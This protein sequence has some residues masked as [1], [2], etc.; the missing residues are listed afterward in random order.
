MP[1]Y[2]TERGALEE[3]LHSLRRQLYEN[4]ELCI[5]DDGST[6]IDSKSI[7]DRVMLKDSRVRV[8][9]HPKNMGT[10]AASQS[11]LTRATGEYIA[12][13]D[14]DDVLYPDALLEIVT[15]LNSDRRLDYIYSDE[16]KIDETGRRVEPYYKPDWSPELILC[17]CYTRHLSVFRRSLVNDLH[18][19]RSEY[20][21]SQDWDLILRV[22]EQTNKIGHIPKILYGWRKTSSSTALS[23]QLKPF[24]HDSAKR[25]LTDAMKRRGKDATVEEGL[26][27]GTF[28]VKRMITGNPLVSVIIPSARISLLKKCLSTLLDVT[29]YRNLEVVIVNDTGIADIQRKLPK[30]PYKI[31]PNPSPQEFNFSAMNNTGVKAASGEYLIFLND[32]TRTFQPTWLESMLEHAQDPEVGAVGAKLLY[33]TGR[34][35][36]A[37]VVV[38]VRGPAGPYDGMSANDH[39]YFGLVDV[40]R[41]CS[42]VTAACMMTRRK[43]FLE[44]GGFDEHLARSW[45]DVDYCL[46]LLNMGLRIVY[47]P[48]A[49]LYHKCGGTR[50]K[51]DWSKGEEKAKQLFTRK[52]HEFIE[53][54][55]PYYNRNLS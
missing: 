18:G 17:S 29:N 3:A 9:R 4:W 32:D 26:F 23:Q 30:F 15:L 25:A 16:D 7:I 52:W 28:R 53:K 8:I 5:C 43:V 27:Y 6:T 41:N 11:A 48:Y 2:N 24:A 13:M 20:E 19:F 38:G 45:Q 40:I 14:D 35:Q 51:I 33:P 1:L 42:A 49:Q 31:V 34:V 46:R 50:G 22:T 12:L 44:S 36:H 39:G 21:G 37:G 47:T 54:G 55:D 10:A